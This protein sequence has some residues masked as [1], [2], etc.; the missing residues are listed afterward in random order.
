MSEIN[1]TVDN[2][3]KM[4]R[5]VESENE[6]LHCENGD[7]SIGNENAV[8]EFPF[9]EG[10]SIS[11]IER[12]IIQLIISEEIIR[13]DYPTD[14]PKPERKMKLVGRKYCY[15]I[16]NDPDLTGQAFEI[17][18]EMSVNG[19]FRE[20]GR[21]TLYSEIIP[22]AY[23]DIHNAGICLPPILCETVIDAREIIVFGRK[24]VEIAEGIEV[25][26]NGIES[27]IIR[28]RNG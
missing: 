20:A 19:I 26:I 14:I 4:V 10:I 15:K 2:V 1:V 25:R 12:E 27:V 11:N 5:I 17:C 22:S 6:L 28:Y 3:T 18:A 7:V 9:D 23:C 8:V 13:L 24:I 21:I 16:K